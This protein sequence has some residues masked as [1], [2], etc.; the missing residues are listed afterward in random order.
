VHPD[1]IL[2]RGKQLSAWEGWAIDVAEATKREVHL[3]PQRI[4]Q[5]LELANEDRIIVAFDL[6]QG[7][8]VVGSIALWHLVESDDQSWG[9]MGSVFLLPEYR[10]SVS[11]LSVADRLYEELL[12]AFPHVNVLATTTNRA[13]VRAGERA[14]LRHVGFEALPEAVRHATCIC[15]ASKTGVS[16]NRSCPLA[17]RTCLVRVSRETHSRMGSPEPLPIPSW[18]R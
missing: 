3:L 4:D 5:L 10:H 9:E 14:G 2:I 15:P 16:D 13:A 12:L 6:S 18:A 17:N 7:R 11:G 1:I 8:R